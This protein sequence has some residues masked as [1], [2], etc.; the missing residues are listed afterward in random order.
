M[1]GILSWIVVGLLIGWFANR[2]MG[3]SYGFIGEMTSGIAGAVFSGFITS[4]L[5][6]FRSPF[7]NI[8]WASI[9]V[10]ALGAL[11]LVA[12]LRRTIG[13]RS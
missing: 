4:Y 7:M 2:L 11:A 10:A 5:L 9:L 12:I 8:H 13:S 3:G 6:D 1:M